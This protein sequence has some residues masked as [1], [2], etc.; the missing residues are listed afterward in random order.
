[1]L[2][3]SAVLLRGSGM[4]GVGGTTAIP[5]TRIP[6]DISLITRRLLPGCRNFS[7]GVKLGQVM[8]SND[9]LT[10]GSPSGRICLV[11]MY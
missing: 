8:V 11:L 1:V 2:I 10:E 9:I 7:A 5:D 4:G 6:G 3:I